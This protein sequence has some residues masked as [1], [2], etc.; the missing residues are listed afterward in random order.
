MGLLINILYINVRRVE[1]IKTFNIIDKVD[2]VLDVLKIIKTR[3]IVKIML[4]LTPIASLNRL[5][6]YVGVGGT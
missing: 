5:I 2:D 1:I 3:N 4:E 6:T